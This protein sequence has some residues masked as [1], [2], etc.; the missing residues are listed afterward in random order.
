VSTRAA[1]ARRQQ[2]LLRLLWRET[3][4]LG[5]AGFAAADSRVERGLQAYRANAFALAERA[6]AAAYP[7]VAQV[8]GG[9]SMAA[10]ARSFWRSHPPEC[11][12]IAQWGAALPAFIAAAPDLA[13]EPYL[14]DLAR[15]DWAVHCAASAGD[16]PTG[17][18]TPA[19]IQRLGDTDPAALRI[20]LAPGAAVVESAH[21]VVTIWRAH[22]GDAADRF[23]PVRAAR[24]RGSAEAGFVWRHGW[25]VEVAVMSDTAIV[26][27]RG[28]V[29]GKRLAAALDAAGPR[30]DFE[31]WLIEA[32]RRGWIAAVRVE[33]VEPGGA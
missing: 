22:L 30:L 29:H 1:E 20:Q 21:P 11:G 26:F 25:R 6:L 33:P 23:E 18:G 3:A 9:G 28:L 14:A 13:S 19:G 16:L 4:D 15:L 2:A 10:L 7:T 8:L 12:D 5:E 24:A 17:S 31:A 32:L 27:M